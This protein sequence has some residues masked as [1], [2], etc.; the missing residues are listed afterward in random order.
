MESLE[1]KRNENQNLYILG[2]IA[3]LLVI[4]IHIGY[5][6]FVGT[7]INVLARTA[8]PLFFIVS[9]Y[10][11]ND[12]DEFAMVRL[13][14][15]I[16]RIFKLSISATILY[17]C[18]GVILHCVLLQE[19]SIFIWLKNLLTAKNL[20]A[21]IVLNSVPGAGHLWFLFSLLYL[22]IF[23]KILYC[24]GK[25]KIINLFPAI[26]LLTVLIPYAF[27][28][29]GRITGFKINLPISLFRNWLFIGLP[30]ISIGVIINRSI[31][32][33]RK[34]R[35]SSYAAISVVGI[36]LSF[37]E[38]SLLKKNMD[39]YFGTIIAIVALFLF[40]C[41]EPGN[42][43]SVLGFIGKKLST[44]IYILHYIFVD[45]LWIIISS[46]SSPE[47]G[48]LRWVAPIVVTLLSILLACVLNCAENRRKGIS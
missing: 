13:N 5:P 42:K 12:I 9:G 22:Y 21:F 18:W 20:V 39:L 47:S 27:V 36:V 30:F 48:M 34:F 32:S 33:V 14:Q 45:I 25:W 44:K 16:R 3:S 1:L 10:F 37:I 28:F 35:P 7:I 8:V 29:Y 23:L 26:L 4:T 31:D 11:L 46:T 40:V 38:R 43:L 19:S 2:G 17:W 24:S 41:V 15:K 6:G